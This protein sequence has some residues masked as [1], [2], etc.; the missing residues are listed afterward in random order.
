MGAIKQSV[1]AGLFRGGF[2]FAGLEFEAVSDV[3]GEYADTPG[4]DALPRIDTFIK[5]D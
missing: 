4:I 5:D 2:Y 1:F 3:F